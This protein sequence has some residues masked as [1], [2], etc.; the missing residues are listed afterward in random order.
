MKTPTHILIGHALSRVIPGEGP[1]KSRWVMLG[2]AAPDVPL[3]GLVGLCYVL[4]TFVCEAD[5]GV[6]FLVDH[7]YFGNEAFI[8]LHHLLHAPASL[9]LCFLVWWLS[10][11]GPK[12]DARGAWFLC[13]AASHAAVDLLTH[14]SDGILL[15]WPLDWSYRFNAG[16]DQWDMSGP[17]GVLLMA[18]VAFAVAYSAHHAWPQLKPLPL[19]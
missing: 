12:R 16:V 8:A 2:A 19:R 3:M 13:G 1:A 6:V 10:T 7:F 14:E 11:S 5:V 9:G 15:L 4:V 17:G 18:E